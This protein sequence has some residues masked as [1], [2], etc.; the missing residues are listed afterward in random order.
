MKKLFLILVLMIFCLTVFGQNKVQSKN[1]FKSEATEIIDMTQ[2]HV[3]RTGVV[4]DWRLSNSPCNGCGSFYYAITRTPE[5][6]IEGKYYYYILAWSNSYYGNGI[7]ATTYIQDIDVDVILSDD[8]E[9][10][11]LGPF[12][13]IIKPKTTTDDGIVYVG[14]VWSTEPDIIIKM[15]WGSVQVY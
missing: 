13:V 15:R 12:Y 3:D 10:H 1:S 2:I 6:D 14:H 4:Y 5:T 8:S 11:V 9:N 7:L